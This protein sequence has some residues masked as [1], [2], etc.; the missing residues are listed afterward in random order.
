MTFWEWMQQVGEVFYRIGREF[1][2]HSHR[3]DALEDR[4]KA[5]EESHDAQS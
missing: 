1:K 4:I 2:A 3:M 5:L